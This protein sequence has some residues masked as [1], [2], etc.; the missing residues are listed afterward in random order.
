[1]VRMRTAMAAAALAATAAGAAAEAQQRVRPTEAE[2]YCTDLRRLVREAPDFAG[3]WRAKPAPPTLGFRPGSCRAHDPTATL[4]AAFSCHQH[5]AP[6]HLAL[7]LLAAQTADCLPALTRIETRWSREAL[8]EGSGV[9]IS[10]FES[11]GP[12]AK[13]GRIVR[14]RVEAVGQPAD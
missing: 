13:V 3:M 2:L 9:R 11:G 12:G 6:A 7:E 5:L 4:P 14:V 1:M 8:F 10:L